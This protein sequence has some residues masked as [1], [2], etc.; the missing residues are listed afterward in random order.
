MFQFP[1]LIHD[2]AQPYISTDIEDFKILHGRS[3]YIKM[4]KDMSLPQRL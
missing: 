4:L 2:P 1:L 3:E